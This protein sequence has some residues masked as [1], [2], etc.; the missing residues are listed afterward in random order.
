MKNGLFENE[1]DWIDD[2]RGGAPKQFEEDFDTLIGGHDAEDGRLHAHKGSITDCDFVAGFHVAVAIDNC[3]IRKRGAK[4]FDYIVGNF[5]NAISEMDDG[6]NAGRMFDLIELG[7]SIEPGKKIIGKETFDKGDNP[8]ASGF[9][10]AKPGAKN[11]D[12]G[13]HP[14]VGSGDVFAFWMGTE[15]KPG[16]FGGAVSYQV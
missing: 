4:F 6:C 16:V 11:L 1:S 2:N 14:Q 3:V 9:A 13:E 15:A 7:P 10:S 12:F 8:A 5:R